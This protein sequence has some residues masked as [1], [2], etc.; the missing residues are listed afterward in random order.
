MKT[1]SRQEFKIR[2]GSGAKKGGST[3]MEHRRVNVQQRKEAREV[4]KS[5]QK[6]QGK[7]DPMPCADGALFHF[8]NSKCVSQQKQA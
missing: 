3:C 4:H 7:L 8:E 1:F 5:K 6:G 2:Q